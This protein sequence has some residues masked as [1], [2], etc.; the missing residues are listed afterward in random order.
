MGIIIHRSHHAQRYV[1]VP[2]AI[3]RNTKLSFRARGLLVMLLSLPPDWHVT[4]DM[5][6]ED[7][8]DSRTAIRAAMAELRESGYVEVHREQDSKGR[9]RTRLEVFDTRQPDA[10]R[11][12]SGATS[13]ND[14]SSQAAPNAGIPAAGGAAAKK[15]YKTSSAARAARGGEAKTRP[16]W[17]GECNELTRLLGEDEP[18][19]CPACHPLAAS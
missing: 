17:C 16:P 18:K 12:A 9:W 4:T 10:S 2:N 19:R 11:P 13:G 3:A 8:P 5:L 1:V 14:T 6:A 15:K 7:N